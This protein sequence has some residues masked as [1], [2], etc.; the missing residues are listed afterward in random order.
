MENANEYIEE[1]RTQLMIGKIQKGYKAILEYLL[2]L[3]QHFRQKYP[4]YSFPGTFY[5]GYLDMSYFAFVTPALKPK[6][7]KIAI[8]FNYTAFRFE[9]WLSGYNK[10]I[11]CKYWNSIK[12]KH[13]DGYFIPKDIEGYDSIIE[14]HIAVESIDPVRTTQEI[15]KRLETFVRIVEKEFGK[16]D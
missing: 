8:V 1:L 10:K 4:D 12:Y 16:P 7:L 9:I 13:M 5:H 15:E 3:Q 2:F 14:D 6:G 11:Q